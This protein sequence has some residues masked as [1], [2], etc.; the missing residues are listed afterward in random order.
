MH[1]IT[2]RKQAEARVTRQALHDPLT[3]LPNRL[4]LLD[5][6]GQALA[7]SE[8]QP[9]S[10][11]ALFVD[12]DRFKAVNDSLGHNVGDR[13]LVAIA[14][15]LT[16][17]VR[18]SDTVARLGGD[19]FVV[20]CEDVAGSD[21]AV[22]L[23]ERLH[24]AVSDEP[25]VVTGTTAVT[26]TASVGVALAETGDLPD[27]LL[28]KADSA[29]YRAKQ[30]GRAR[31]ELFDEAFRAEAVDRLQAENDLRRA[32]EEDRLRLLYQPVIDLTSGAMVGVEALLRYQDHTRG[33][34]GPGEFLEVAEDS[35]LIV[36]IGAWALRQACRQMRQWHDHLGGDRL[37]VSVNLSARQLAGSGLVESL[38]TTLRE[39]NAHTEALSLEIT[40]NSA[41]GVGRTDAADPEP[42]QGRRPAAGDRRLRNGLLVPDLPAPL[43]GGLRQD[44]PVV[45]RGAGHR[46]RGHRDRH[47]SCRT[48]QGTGP[49]HGRR[50]RGDR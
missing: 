25:L 40:E 10:I 1:D 9:G 26:L 17:A 41:D 44:R 6:L 29:M 3:G 32:L 47:G 39:E 14:E 7:R 21:E 43:P 33:L 48:G 22:T 5:R 8:R 15:R 28:R 31:H 34:V 20:L 12:F 45:C 50:G 23:V 42:P 37:R 24:A 49:D 2:D 13:T 18:P 16:A 4:L 35:G 27:D 30:R 36:P 46:P 11:A 38:V 19:E